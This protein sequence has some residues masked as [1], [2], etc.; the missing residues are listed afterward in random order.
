V[1][2]VR[3]VRTTGGYELRVRVFTGRID[4]GQLT[5]DTWVELLGMGGGE[6]DKYFMKIHFY[7]N[8]IG[9][10]LI[11]GSNNR[12]GSMAISRD[13]QARDSQIEEY[14]QGIKDGLNFAF[15]YAILATAQ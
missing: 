8:S 4:F 6:T 15:E 5:S 14:H 9:W 10:E 13:S 1:G 2:V 3:Y 12:G 11:T 7:I